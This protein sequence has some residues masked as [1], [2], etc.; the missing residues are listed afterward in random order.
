MF[1]PKEIMVVLVVLLIVLMVFGPKRIKSLGSELGNAIK[2][3]RNAVKE[4][5]AESVAAESV[6][7]DPSSSDAAG[8]HANQ[9]QNV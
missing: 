4:K 7:H 9:K 2:G 3:F 5:D 8:V 6:A 1:G